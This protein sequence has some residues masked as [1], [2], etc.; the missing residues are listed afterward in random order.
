MHTE[1]PDELGGRGVGSELAQ[2]ALEWARTQQL[3]VKVYC[4][5]VKKY[6]QRHKEYEDVLA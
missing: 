5:F 1:V 3:K 4:A 2:H 6:L